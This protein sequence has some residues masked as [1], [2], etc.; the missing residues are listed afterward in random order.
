ME[1]KKNRFPSIKELLPYLIAIALFALLTIIYVS[2]ILEGKRLLQSD[3]VN[4]KGMA[5]E[6]E[7][8]REETGKEALWTNSMFGGMPAYQISVKWAYNVSGLFHKIL[9]LGLPRPADMI[10]LY[11]IGFFI[12]LLLLRVNPWVALL[13]AIG[14]A[15]SSYHFIILEAGHNS[16]AVAIAYMAP[17]MASIIYTFRGKRLVGG[18]L[19]A[20]FMG[21]QLYANHFQITYYLAW[22]V[23]FYG[24][25]EFYQHLREGQL[26]RF[27]K[28][29]LVL[30]AGLVIAAGLNIGNFW[31]TFVYSSETMRGG[32]ELTIGDREPTS[33]LSK[34]YIT[35]WS[36][37]IGET[38]SLLIPNAKGGATGALG[39]IP[40]AMQAVDP[41]FREFV[42]QQNHY[43]GDQPFTSGPVYVGAIVL[44]FFILG[45]FFVKGPLKWGLLL[46]TIL[47]IM[48][49]WGKNFMPLTD[50][51]IDFIPGYDK[52]RAVSMT[53]V[54]AEFTIP[55]LAFLGL[56]QLYQKPELLKI[57]S[58]EFITALG[59]TAGIAFLF[60]IAPT[61]FFKFTS[62]MES[63]YFASQIAQNQQ[64]SAQI[65]LFLAQL[66]DARIAVFRSDAIRSALFIVIAA[67]VT[68]LFS[69]K[70]I[71][72]TVF[73]LLI[74]GLIVLD[75]WPVNKRYLN[76]SNF[77]AR[78]LVETPY[79]P[80]QANLQIL[81]D[82]DPHFRVLNRATNTFNETSTSWFHKSLGGY[83]GAKLQRYQDLIEFYIEPGNMAVLNM[84]NTK[85]VIVPGE[86]R[87][88]VARLNPGALGNA[89]FVQDTKTV[90]TADEEILAL[91][92]FEPGTT[93]IVHK[94]FAGLL[95][96][97]T[98]VPD[99]LA[100]ISL[101]EYQPNYLKYQY[102]TGTDQLAVFS[103]IYYPEGWVVRIN[104]EKA[105][106]LRVNYL[107]RG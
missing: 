41:Q 105:P 16:K 6:I 13:G 48:L 37:G 57:K 63:E 28:G 90:Q 77:Q 30:L 49:A 55:A 107:L 42:S 101:I 96:G 12:F 46:A 89:W 74:A 92:A 45:V 69:L 24:L 40:K 56:H 67:G 83:H 22:I 44:F 53:L 75:M 58:K 1:S 8:Y 76:D 97:Q 36:Y 98:L 82:P 60:Y 4:Y 9:T 29:L 79:Q 18:L 88:P 43:W 32:S 70:K 68:L 61:V 84:L 15:L 27:S 7:D 87:Q 2:P 94:D 72:G 14:F 5:K 93:A 25:F 103:E 95:E 99:S 33:G 26:L 78:R 86:N 73:V 81:Q 52:F 50:F 59:L 23:V 38:F 31:A 34:D 35:N 11:F 65:N 104:G 100:S 66:E 51:F 39:E 21:L 3:I 71:K 17:V 102:Q 64:A 80:T 62:Q 106:P 19:F 54:I 10:F 47:S 20:I 85:Y 91:D